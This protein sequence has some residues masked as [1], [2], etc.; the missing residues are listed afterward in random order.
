MEL[1]LKFCSLPV[2]EIAEKPLM[3]IELLNNWVTLIL[4]RISDG[5]LAGFVSDFKD[6]HP[7]IFWI[8]A[9]IWAPIALFLGI[10]FFE[11]IVVNGLIVIVGLSILFTVVCKIIHIIDIIFNL[12]Q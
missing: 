3:L 8:S 11:G 7:M 4:D 1:F 5:H 9:I 6:N 10:L 2:P 12:R